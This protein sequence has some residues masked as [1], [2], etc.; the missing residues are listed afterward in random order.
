MFTLF[1]HHL[2]KFTIVRT[3]E[4]KVLPTL[5]NKPP[6]LK[7]CSNNGDQSPASKEEKIRYSRYKPYAPKRIGKQSTKI[8]QKTLNI[9]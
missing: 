9:V 4:S 7:K 8:D 5:M 3:T 6:T 1:Y 2:I